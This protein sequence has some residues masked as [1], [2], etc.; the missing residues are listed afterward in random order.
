MMKKALGCLFAAAVL[1]VSA[2]MSYAYQ[3]DGSSSGYFTNPSPQYPVHPEYMV[4]TGVGTNYFTWGWGDPSSMNFSGASFAENFEHEFKIGTLTY[5][6]G[7]IS[8]GTGASSVDLID[9]L[10]FTNPAGISTQ[11]AFTFSLI[12]TINT[13]DPVAS[14]DYVLLKQLYDPS[15][16]FNVGGTDYF[17]QFTR[18]G[19]IQQDGFSPSADQ[20]HVY[21]GG[22]AS[23]DMFAKLTASPVNT[24]PEAS[25]MLLFGAGLLGLVPFNMFVKK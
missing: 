15:A 13:Y 4:V 25:A 20:F 21:E 23:A 8:D 18:F 22:A 6:N 14:A 19:N 24:V 16:F 5:Y 2:S 7:A 9:T 17:L 1:A 11:F 3:F 10:D 12:N